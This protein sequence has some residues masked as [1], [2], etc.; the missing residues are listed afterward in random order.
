[1]VLITI[2]NTILSIKKIV[3][4]YMSILSTL[5]NR[6]CVYQPVKITIK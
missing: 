2:I 4:L 5:G 1:M 6:G 3:S